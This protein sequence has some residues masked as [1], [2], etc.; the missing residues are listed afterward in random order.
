MIVRKKCIFVSKT[1]FTEKK[2]NKKTP[3][4]EITWRSVEAADGE[5]VLAR[6]L[7][8]VVYEERMVAAT[9]I[10][11]GRQHAHSLALLNTP[12]C[13]WWQILERM[14]TQML[15]TLGTH[16]LLGT[17]TCLGQQTSA[18]MVPHMSRG[19]HMSPHTSLGAHKSA[20]IC[21]FLP[22]A[23]TSQIQIQLVFVKTFF[24]VFSHLMFVLIHSGFAST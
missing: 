9:V 16:G 20:C 24:L 2:H 19:A 5:V 8:G 3:T 13:Q 10:Q 4:W 6:G 18:H 7:G 12:E 23:H 17:H 14:C 11:N 1:S 15:F 21:A 22:W